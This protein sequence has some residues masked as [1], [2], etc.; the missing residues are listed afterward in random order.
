MATTNSINN[1][2]ITATS[3]TVDPE[4]ASDSYVQFSINTTEEFRIGVDDTDDSCRISQGSALGTNDTLVITSAG[5]ITRPLTPAF[6]AVLAST[7]ADVTG[8]A[9]AYTVV[10]D[11]EVFDQNGDF[12]GTSTFTSHVTG[13]YVL[14]VGIMFDDVDSANTTGHVEITTSNRAYLS[15]VSDYGNWFAS[16]SQI[17]F[18]FSV[19]ADM[20]AADTA[21][22]EVSVSNGTKIVDLVSNGST[23]P[24]NWFSG[25][26]QC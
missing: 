4:A 26:L 11:T 21:L 15:C 22:I 23:D 1:N 7:L 24:Y 9:T 6:L 16:D 3:L 13:R 10:W 8:D 12:D 2:N 25:N 19:L 18:S 17:G 14:D 5:E 20:D